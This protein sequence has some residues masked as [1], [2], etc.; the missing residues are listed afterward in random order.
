MHHA[1]ENMQTAFSCH[2]IC[3]AACTTVKL[4]ITDIWL[5]GFAKTDK[6]LFSVVNHCPY[7]FTSS[8]T[9]RTENTQQKTG[10]ETLLITVNGADWSKR[11]N[12]IQ[13]AYK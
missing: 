5:V 4:A 1:K 9:T 12:E 13:G 6:N 7:I 10:Q 3:A 8:K 11:S 2:P